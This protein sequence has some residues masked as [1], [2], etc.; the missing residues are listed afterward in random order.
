VISVV[1]KDRVR[2]I[3]NMLLCKFDT[4][5]PDKGIAFTIPISG[6]SGPLALKYI[7]GFVR[8]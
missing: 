7:S 6:V 8:A 4:D 3:L 1:T 2:E 5:K